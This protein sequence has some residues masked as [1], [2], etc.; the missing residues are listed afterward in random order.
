MVACFIR[1]R[2]ESVSIQR[3]TKGKR[4]CNLIQKIV[5]TYFEAAEEGTGRISRFVSKKI[6]LPKITIPCEQLHDN[7]FPKQPVLLRRNLRDPHYL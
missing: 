4:N 3:S 1:F 5:V 6:F 2:V 7:G